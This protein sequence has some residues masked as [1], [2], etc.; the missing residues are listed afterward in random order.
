MAHIVLVSAGVTSYLNASYKIAHQLHARGDHVTFVSAL[1][2]AEAQVLAQGFDF[3]LLREE[4][5][6]VNRYEALSKQITQ[7]RFKSLFNRAERINLAKIRHDHQLNSNELEQLIAELDPDLL[8]ID[9]ELG[10]HIIRVMALDIPVL[11]TDYHCSPRR[12]TGVPILSSNLIPTGMLWNQWAMSATWHL[13]YLQQQLKFSL[14]PIYYGGIKIDWMSIL[15]ALA[16]Q[17]G[18]DFDAEFDLKQWHSITP[19]SIRTLICAAWEFDFPHDSE[20]RDDYVG[21]M[22][23]LERQE[24]V[25]DPTYQS[26]LRAIAEKNTPGTKRFLIYCSMGTFYSNYDY[27][28][29]VIRAVADKPNYDLILAV[30]HDLSLDDF[31]PTP[32]NVYLFQQ[33][34]Q[35]DL[36]KRADIVLTHGGIG[37]INECI[38]LG[39]PMVV[40]S[41]GYY[42]RNGCAARVAY[43]G[44]GLRG[45]FFRD[46]A[47]EIGQNIEQVLHNPQYRANVERMRETYLAYHDSDRV[48]ELIHDMLE[49]SKDR[50]D[51]NNR[52]H[53]P[54]DVA[55]SS[56]R[57]TQNP[58]LGS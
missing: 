35:L 27:F 39:V 13:A 19:R 18:L 14:G 56:I 54:I 21:P 44:M 8:I 32:D 37:T 34:P 11:L 4:A 55:H 5:E 38:L 29:R 1:E 50:F 9:A 20:N 28:Q 31:E 46:T 2:S 25:N 12:A 40:Y 43:H 26:V 51:E 15:R 36:L 58:W 33:V 16:R 10:A 53:A 57:P 22:V 47:A 3:I 24:P 6:V 49:S 48:V 23:L 45:D 42:D 7:H 17:R 41:D 30:G 52:A